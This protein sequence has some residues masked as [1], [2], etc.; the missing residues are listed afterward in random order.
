MKDDEKRFLVDVYLKCRSSTKPITSWNFWEILKSAKDSV[1]PR[2]L[3]NEPN[4]YMHHK[5]AWYL[6]S[7]W[8]SK[9]W[10]EWGV[11]MDLGWLTPEGKN[12]A[13]EIIKSQAEDVIDNTQN[14]E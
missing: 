5:R 10:Y 8:G 1:K 12:K 7:K 11:T 4:F 2:D 14:I 13:E 3:I 6:L 9:R